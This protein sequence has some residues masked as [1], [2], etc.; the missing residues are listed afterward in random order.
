MNLGVLGDDSIEIV[1]VFFK[2]ESYL[3]VNGFLM[4]VT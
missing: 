1:I 4:L 3:T 2:K